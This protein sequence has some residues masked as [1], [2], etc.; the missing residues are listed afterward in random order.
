NTLKE[1]GTPISIVHNRHLYVI[2]GYVFEMSSSV[3]FKPSFAVK[4]TANAPI[5]ADINASFLFYEKLWLGGMYRLNESFGANI[6]LHI[7]EYL[8]VG[9]VYDFTT[10]A[11]RN[12]SSGSHE[13]MLGFDFRSKSKSVKSPRYF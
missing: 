7:N 12:Y 8:R 1:G 3:D 4:Y 6:M 13:I 5:S 9:Y 10:T 2:A 11:I